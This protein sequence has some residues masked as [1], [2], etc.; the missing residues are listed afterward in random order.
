MLFDLDGTLIDTAPDMAAALNQLLAEENKAPIAY[1]DIR[2]HV[3]QGAAGLL[4]LAWTRQAD[5]DRFEALRQRFLEIYAELNGHESV[6]FDGYA[7]ILDWLDTSGI[8]WG[9]VT[10]KPAW[11]AEPLIRHLGIDQRC[12]CLVCGDTLERRKPHPAQLVHAAGLLNAE[13]QECVYIGDSIRDMQAAESADMAG[14]A[15]TYGYIPGGT[16]PCSWP[17]TA[18]IDKPGDLIGLIGLK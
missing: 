9:I 2:P 7:E 12:A 14:I 4:D 15:A 8:S 10:N 17:T 5:E 16:D 6:L 1:R 18:M 11:L 13:P 3:S